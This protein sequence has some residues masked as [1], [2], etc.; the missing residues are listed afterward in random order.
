[1]LLGALL[2]RA[3]RPEPPWLLGWLDARWAPVA[4]PAMLGGWWPSALHA[5][6]FTCLLGVAMGG[7]R[8]VALIAGAFWVSVALL[9]ELACLGG[10]LYGS[11]ALFPGGLGC[12]ADPLDVLAAIAGAVLAIVLF[13]TGAPAPGS[14]QPTPSEESNP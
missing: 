14:I 9:A 2:Y 11:H 8:R 13:P 12:Q 1:M 3:C 10:A 5:F 4:C 6:A 7:G